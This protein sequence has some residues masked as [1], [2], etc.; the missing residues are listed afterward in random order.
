LPGKI[1]AAVFVVGVVLPLLLLR[2][3]ARRFAFAHLRVGTACFIDLVVSVAQISGVIVIFFADRLDA[4]TAL[5]ATGIAASIG[6]SM[7]L[8]TMRRSFS[9]RLELLASSIREHWRFGRW[10][11]ASNLLITLQAYA[12]HWLLAF[13][14][15]TADTGVYSACLTSVRVLNPLLLG[16]GNVLGPMAARA[17]AGGGL[18]R[19]RTLMV[20]VSSCLIPM[21]GLYCILVHAVGDQVIAFLYGGSE[22]LGHGHLLSVL[23][24]TV[25]I[26]AIDLPIDAGLSAMNRPDIGFRASV[27]STLV[28]VVGSFLLIPKYG[29][30]GGAYAGLLG[31]SC[32]AVL[33][34]LAIY[35]FLRTVSG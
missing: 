15:G 33:R 13:I 11:L 22:Y 5:I 30:L 18:K 16:V 8:A 32:G 17:F 29:M 23:A 3:F 25:F 24:L 35:R 21:L 9:I 27:V 31:Q 20:K 10:V 4:T 26:A 12:V 1:N 6:G 14:S 2:E 19:L 28:V 34:V 7:G